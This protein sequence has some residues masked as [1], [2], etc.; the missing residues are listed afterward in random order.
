MDQ[1]DCLQRA[2][3][4]LEF[5]NLTFVVPLDHI[6]AVNGDAVNLQLKFQYSI[7]VTTELADVTK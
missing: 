6:D 4:Y 7:A 2:D 5:C 1:I 3:H